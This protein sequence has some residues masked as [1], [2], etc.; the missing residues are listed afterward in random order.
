MGL[1]KRYEATICFGKETD[2]LDPEGEVIATA[3]LPQCNEIYQA[4]PGLRGKIMQAPP[5]YSAIHVGGQRAYKLAREKKQIR[6]REREVEVFALEVTSCNLPEVDIELHCS[7]GTYVRSLARDLGSACGSAA[8]LTS[9]NRTAVGDFIVEDAV[10][11]ERVDVQKHLRNPAAVLAEILGVEMVTVREEAIKRVAQGVP[12]EL[13]FFESPP[14]NAGIFGMCDK[15]GRLR[16]VGETS[17]GRYAYRV[18]A[19]DNGE[20]HDD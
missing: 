19:P 14:S 12:I 15:R 6:M 5:L 16:A 10:D 2:T 17:D 11:P 13:C 8:H 4:L 1:P 20:D 9:L 3:P 7:K 18:V